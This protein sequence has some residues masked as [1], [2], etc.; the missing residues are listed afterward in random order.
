V[1]AHAGRLDVESMAPSGTRFTARILLLGT[2]AA[3]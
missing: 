1:R 2:H 3:G